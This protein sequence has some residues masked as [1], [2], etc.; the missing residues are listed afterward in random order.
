MGL[1]SKGDSREAENERRTSLADR[2]S[3][4]EEV[5]RKYQSS[6]QPLARVQERVVGEEPKNEVVTVAKKSTE[7]TEVVSAN[8]LRKPKDIPKSPTGELTIEDIMRQQS[9]TMNQDKK[10][11]IEE[12]VVVRVREKIKL[13]FGDRIKNEMNEPK[14]KGEIREA[15]ESALMDEGAAVPTID[16]RERLKERIYNL[17]MGFGPLEVL[18]KQGYSE[19][20]VTH[21]DRIFVEDKGRMILKEIQFGSEEELHSIIEQMV[22]RIGRVVND[23]TPLVDGRLEDGSRFNAVLP[24]IVPDGAQLTIRRFPENKLTEEDYLSFGTLSRETLWFLKKAV[25]AKWNLIVSGG[26]GSGKTS[27]LNLMSNFLSYDPG[28]SVVTIEDSCELQISHP[29]VRRYETRQANAAG[30]GEVTS[31]MLVK[32]LMRVRPDV[33]IIGEIRDGTMADFLRLNTSG[34]EGGMTTVHNNSPEELENTIQVLFQMAQDYNF[35]ENAIS[36]LYANA[37]DLVIQIKRY[38]DHVRRISHISHVVGYGK[39]G[40]KR[41]NIQFGDPDYNPEEVYIR[42]IYRW[43]QTGIG[44]NGV[45]TGEFV[46]TGYVPEELLEKAMTNGVVIDRNIFN[47]GYKAEK[48]G[49]GVA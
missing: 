43:K 33:A 40:A 13:R 35:T 24:P 3:Q 2:I 7:I 25:E 5:M 23:S 42:D 18:F 36:R 29:N 4:K 27:L 49:N 44:E 39:L 31:R 8:K 6:V 12:E 10:K 14:F 19:I 15:I 11:Q 21:Y 32:N 9:R 22:A 1:F 28:L 38:K 26:T 47:C 34:H 17:I 48:G 41:L 45:F 37:V 16:D 30:S 20:M 46:A